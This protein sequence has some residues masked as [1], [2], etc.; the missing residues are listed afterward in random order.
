M[1]FLAGPYK[2]EREAEKKAGVI[3]GWAVYQSDDR[4]ENDWNIVLTTTY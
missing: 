3:T 1:N 4:D 2:Q